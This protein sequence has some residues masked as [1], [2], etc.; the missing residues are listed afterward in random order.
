KPMV[1]PNAS[2][3]SRSLTSLSSANRAR[4]AAKR[5]RFRTTLIPSIADGSPA[6][7]PSAHAISRVHAG[8]SGGIGP[9]C[10]VPLNGCGK[11]RRQRSYCAKTETALRARRV[12][13][14]PRLSVW[15]TCVPLDLPLEPT[16]VRDHFDQIADGNFVARTQVYRFGSVV[17]FGRQH[18]GFGGIGSIEESA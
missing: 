18:Q 9:V 10:L 3:A 15:L 17:S 4:K 2:N 8:S 7:A 11:T 14:A 13:T 5:K 1:A 6:S 12:Q 16:Q